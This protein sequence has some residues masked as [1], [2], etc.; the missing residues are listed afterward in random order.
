[1]NGKKQCCPQQISAATKR[2][3]LAGTN[4]SSAPDAPVSRRSPSH[5]PHPLQCFLSRRRREFE[6]DRLLFRKERLEIV[7]TRGMQSASGHVR[8]EVV[9]HV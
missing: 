3:F 9:G 4:E 1:M 6:N 8:V 7:Q 2:N 5:N